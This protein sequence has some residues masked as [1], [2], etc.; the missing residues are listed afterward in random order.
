M[1]RSKPIRLEVQTE[2]LSSTPADAVKVEPGTSARNRSGRSEDA[3]RSSKAQRAQAPAAGF[4]LRV[5]YE[6]KGRGGQP[7][8]VLYAFTDKACGGTDAFCDSPR[9]LAQK[10]KGAL[11]CGGTVEDRPE[12]RV[13]VQC[14]DRER[15]VRV[16]E[17]WGLRAQF[18]G[19]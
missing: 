10:L 17:Q 11:S 13:I 14:R 18:S 3:A 5:R 15:L 12:P 2:L 4:D 7:V 8:F 16:L 19:G 9:S 6:A 1:V